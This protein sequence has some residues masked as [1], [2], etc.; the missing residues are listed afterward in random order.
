MAAKARIGL[1]RDKVVR[2]AAVAS[3][4]SVAMPIPAQRPHTEKL[5]M[6]K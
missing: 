1:V 3:F 5:T 2:A 6:K 4:Q